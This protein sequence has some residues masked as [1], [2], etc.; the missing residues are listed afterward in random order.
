MKIVKLIL[1]SFTFLLAFLTIVI[2]IGSIACKFINLPE[3]SFI[4]MFGYVAFFWIILIS[5]VVLILFLILGRHRSALS[6]FGLL[7]LF[8]LLLD[9]FSFQYV[10]HKVPK[11]TESFDSLNIIAYNVKY[12]S[13]GI[14]NI[15]EYIKKSNYDIVLLSES[16]LTPEKMTYLKNSLPQYTVLS[17]NGHDL[18]ILSK[19]PVIS[20]KIVDMPT[21]L[22]SL[23]SSN[24]ISKLKDSGI[25]RSFVHAIINVNGTNINVLSLR[26]IAGRP[27]NHTIIESIRWGKYLVNAQNDE[28]L[29]FINY[30]QTLTGPVLFGGDLNVPP[31]TAIIHKLKH[32]AS[33]TYI[34]QH[35]F[36]SRTFKVSFPTMRLDYLFHS[37]DIVSKKSEVVNMKPPLSDHFPISAEFL[38]P[39]ATPRR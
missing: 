25:H 1:S 34:E 32:Y 24:D 11:T 31:N 2:C 7:V 5:A 12:Y 17:D 6:Y 16:V 4:Q 18:S 28:L 29:T 35:A 39:K 30:L 20:Y 27:K 22:A 37:K 36:G 3:N 10:N 33:D 9:D 21:Y 13:Y 38:V 26:L 8:A 19:Y 15:S 23:S 14:E